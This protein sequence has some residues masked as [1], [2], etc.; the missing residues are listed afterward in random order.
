[1]VHISEISF[2]D[3]VGFN[4][5]SN[6]TKKWILESLENRYGIKIIAKHFDKFQERSMNNLN[7]NLHMLCVRTN[8]NPYFLYLVK[9]NFT[10]YCILIDK[11]VQQGYFYPRM[12]LVRLHF[13]NDLFEKE[14]IFDGEM[15]KN[16]D[17]SWSYLINDVIVHEGRYLNNMNLAKRLHLCLDMLEKRFV[18][19]SL[20][21]FNVLVKGY[22]K[23]D[24]I[25]YMVKEYIP[26]RP[27]T[28]RGLYFKPLYLK[29]RE[30]LVNFDDSLVQKVERIK[31]KDV[32]QFLLKG[33]TSIP[34]TN[35]QVQPN[36][37]N[38][39]KSTSPPS[40][41]SSFNMDI[42]PI[43]KFFVK[44]T[45]DPDVY[46]LY[47]SDKYFGIA[48]I[49]NM[50]TSKYMKQIFQDKNIVTKVELDL[51]YSERFGKYIPVI[52]Y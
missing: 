30:T 18:A 41:V 27:Y 11:K 19:S 36:E 9:I 29:F 37:I 1:M 12:I 15:V 47:D 46:E 22:F 45:S 31:F 20:D 13:D 38:T 21:V 7:N 32:K 40:S 33:D 23:Y 35:I 25:E 42:Q 52:K 50:K 14:T 17:S 28:C 10:N 43:R 3:K 5:K 16:K 6:D 4:I 26:N 8:G 34:S 24:E 2:C 49:P 39:S 51:E 48:C 44:K